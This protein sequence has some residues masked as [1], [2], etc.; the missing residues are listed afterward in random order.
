M[1]KYVVYRRSVLDSKNYLT[2][3]C[4]CLCHTFITITRLITASSYE[5][6]ITPHIPDWSTISRLSLRIFLFLPTYFL[7]LFL[8]NLH[9][10]L[11]YTCIV[12]YHD[13]SGNRS[14]EVCIELYSKYSGVLYLV[15]CFIHRNC[16]LS[17]YRK[18]CHYFNT[19]D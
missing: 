10:S 9:V 5:K 7:I 17:K 6:L 1:E 14:W 13:K 2:H 19:T 8:I 18:K 11:A 4:N 16:I 3:S 15:H 12:L